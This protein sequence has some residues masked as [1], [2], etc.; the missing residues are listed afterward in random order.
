M[1]TKLTLIAFLISMLFIN[2]AEAQFLKKLKKT[3]E[4][5]VEETV[6][7]KAADKASEKASK[8]MDKIFDPSFGG[9]KKGEKVVPQNLPESFS[10]EYKYQLMMSTTKGDMKMDYLLKPGA[11]YLGVSMDVGPKMFMIMDGEQNISYMFIDSND[12]KICTAT[13]LD[14]TDDLDDEMNNLDNYTIT[15]LPNKTFLGYDCPGLQMENDDYVFIMY[16]T[17]EAPVSFNDVFKTDPDRIPVALKSHFNE[18]QNS[19]MMYMDMKDKK[20]KGK[21]NTSGTMEC[22]S[23]ETTDFELSTAGYKLM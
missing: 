10:F 17:N 13:S 11:S 8:S 22:T 20:N 12:N 7:N 15:S 1:K 21:K 19:L 3:V 9:G 18:N 2:N 4:D 5:A 14:I 16:Y 6:I 23:L